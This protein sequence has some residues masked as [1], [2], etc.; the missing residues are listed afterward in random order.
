[1]GSSLQD[2]FLKMGLVNK[3]KYN[4]SKKSRHKKVVKAEAK[5]NEIAEM[6]KQ[7]LVEKKK[8]AQQHNKKRQA[9]QQAK[10]ATAKARQLI[11]THKI[12]YEE[13]SIAYNFKDNTTIKKIFLPQK[14]IDS[15]AQGKSGIVKLAGEYQFVPADIIY[16]IR[17]LN[18]KMI[19]LFNSPSANK[20]NDEDDPYAEF[21]VPDDLMW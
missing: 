15:L 6:A 20:G 7:A 11:E 19:V 12:S 14:A 16:K 18:N 17:A 13:G 21:E 10:E 5:D 4:E 1:M 3:K 8:Q 2:Q 9:E